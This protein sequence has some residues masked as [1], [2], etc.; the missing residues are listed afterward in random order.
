MKKGGGKSKGNSFERSVSKRLSLWITKGVNSNVFWRSQ[1][2]GGRATILF[3]SDNELA[4]QAGDIQATT[5]HGTKF[6][7]IFTIECKHYAHIHIESFIYGTPKTGVLS[8]WEQVVRDSDLYDKLP[9]LIAKQNSKPELLIVNTR[10][11]EL[12]ASTGTTLEPKATIQGGIYIYFFSEFLE[13]VDPTV[14]QV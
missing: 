7:D 10:G 4:N 5:S 13:F 14:F 11:M 12:I 9:M 2:S 3:K 1:N 8:F 6:I